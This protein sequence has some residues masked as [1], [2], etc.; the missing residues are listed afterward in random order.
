MSSDLA[1]CDARVCALPKRQNKMA[2][3]ILDRQRDY[4]ANVSH[5]PGPWHSFAASNSEGINNFFSRSFSVL[6]NFP[7]ANKYLY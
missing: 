4:P 6:L 7:P 2:G 3:I 1:S 5:Y